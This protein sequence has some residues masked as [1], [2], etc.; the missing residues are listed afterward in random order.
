MAV[1]LETGEGVGCMQRAEMI[2][3]RI[4]QAGRYLSRCNTIQDGQ[5]IKRRQQE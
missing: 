3:V 5:Q 1:R 2:I 4:D